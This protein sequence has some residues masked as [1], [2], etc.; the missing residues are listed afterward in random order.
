MGKTQY[1]KPVNSDPSKE[2]KARQDNLVSEMLQTGEITEKVAE[3]LQLGGDKLSKYYHLLKTHNIP[4]D[5]E[6]P[7]DWLEEQGFPIR[8]IISGR[9]GPTERLAGFIDHFLQP[10]MK[11]LKTFLK[12][13]KHTLQIIENINEKIDKGELSLEGVHLVSL[14]VD[15]MYNNITTDLGRGAAKSYLDS[16]PPLP[17]GFVDNEDPF[18]STE[19]L[20]EGLDLCIENN[21][22]Q[23]NKKIYKQVGGVGT[24]IKLAPPYACLAMG[25]FEDTVF[26]TEEE[27]EQQLLD[28]VILWKRFIDDI[29][30]LIKGTEAECGKL[31]SWLNNILPG[32]IKLKCNFSETNLE[33]LDLKIMIVNGRLETELY[34]KPTNLQLFLSYDSNHPS[35]C[36][37]GIVYSQALRVIERCSLPDSAQPHLENLK[38]KFL[39]RKYPEELI[40]NQFEKAKLKQ[41]KDLIFQERKKKTKDN[42]IR[43]IFTN[44]SQNPPL[45]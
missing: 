10:G 30:M 17:S 38:G 24:G 5:L 36:K 11:A 39:N 1:Y 22:F 27:E 44:N 16:R 34:V 19:S 7:L 41:R 14:D 32:V 18:V 20:L 42:K 29:L 3:Y 31:V 23:Y 40:D 26:N 21:Y 45:Q 13:T 2:I 28:M 33:F 25:K 9:G 12:D 43:L 15:K 8:G 4:V 35:H 6:N 37:D